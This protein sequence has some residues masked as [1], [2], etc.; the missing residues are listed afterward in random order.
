M[1]GIKEAMERDRRVGL[2]GLL[3]RI[4]LL[5]L[6]ATLILSLFLFRGNISDAYAAH[7]ARV[8]MEE[9]QSDARIN[10]EPDSM[11]MYALVQND[12][13]VLNKGTYKLYS[14]SGDEKVSKQ[15]ISSD[16]AM[17]TS[18]AGTVIY[19]RGSGSLTVIGTSAIA[20]DI[21]VSGGIVDASINDSGMI[22]VV[23]GDERYRSVV[24]V[25]NNSLG[26]E[27]EW[28]TSEYY[29]LTAALSPDG[30]SL[31]VVTLTQDDAVFITRVVIFRLDSEEYHSYCDLTAT[32]VTDLEFLDDNT[33]CAI[34]DTQ[35]AVINMEGKVKYQYNYRGNS[36]VTCSCGTGTCVL[37][38]VDRNSG[39]NSLLVSV[40]PNKEPV[41]VSCDTVRWVDVNGN[42]VAV[43]YS[44]TV[45]MRNLELEQLSEPVRIHN[46]NEVLVTPAGKVMM[47]YTSQAGIVDLITPFR[48]H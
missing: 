3:R 27:Y 2:F 43:L 35:T 16:P 21:E 11:N 1:S 33:V 46:V 8:E 10:F 7:E 48:A 14:T 4:M 15:Y 20:G 32:L 47:I 38:L 45:E 37:A 39:L 41:E 24:S 40:R 44:D 42:H 25:Y 26:L 29:I 18:K 19:S 5:G 34:G 28:K 22:A 36:L 17:D 9:S 23:H 30:Y 31:A 6:I 13:A 12:L